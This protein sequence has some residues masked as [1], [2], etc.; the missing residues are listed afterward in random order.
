MGRA[1]KGRA[2]KRAQQQRNPRTPQPE[3]P[4]EQQSPAAPAP[5]PPPAPFPHP[6]YQQDYTAFQPS[7][8]TLHWLYSLPLPPGCDHQPLPQTH[9]Q[10]ALV[11][12]YRLLT[13]GLLVMGAFERERQRR[14]AAGEDPYTDWDPRDSG[15]PAIVSAAHSLFRHDMSLQQHY[16]QPEVTAAYPSSYGPGDPDDDE[17]Y[18]SYSDGEG[19]YEEDEDY[20]DDGADDDEGE[21][22]V[23]ATHTYDFPTLETLQSFASASPLDPSA[24]PLSLDLSALTLG[25]NGLGDA[26]EEG[27]T[28]A[29]L[30]SLMSAIA[31]LE[32]CVA[33]L[34]LEA[35]EARNLQKSLREEMATRQGQ[36]ALTTGGGEDGGAITAQSIA[37]GLARA[38]MRPMKKK[39]KG[40]RVVSVSNR[41]RL[42]SHLQAAIQQQQAAA[43]QA[44]AAATA[45]QQQQQQQQQARPAPLSRAASKRPEVPHQLDDHPH[46]HPHL[47]SHPHDPHS[48]DHCTDCGTS[49]SRSASPT[50]SCS[51]PASPS[52]PTS[53]P[54]SPSVTAA[55]AEAA[56]LDPH[57]NPATNRAWEDGELMKAL[58]S[59][60]MLD[61]RADEYRERLRVLKEQIHHHAA[62]ADALASSQSTQSAQSPAA[63]SVAPVVAGEKSAFGHSVSDTTLQWVSVDERRREL[64]RGAV[65]ELGGEVQQA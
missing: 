16:P 8:D 33:R 56:G 59:V 60:S 26:N 47:H 12:Q 55:A 22:G 54:A 2:A 44:V 3:P 11:E 13:Q 62:L 36:P 46:S 57:I 10:W 1:N 18:A 37:A 64:L 7:Q 14:E 41:G 43:Q 49:L 38:G 40:G 25:P 31:E 51:P 29:S 23:L 58:Q 24:L 20:D 6:A 48:H 21:D 63:A 34:S 9:E 28:P 42:P 35:T 5:P 52:P 65:G 19:S 50:C 32:Q 61:R 30:P 4:L 15:N 27:G 53:A 45:A 39:V 17:L